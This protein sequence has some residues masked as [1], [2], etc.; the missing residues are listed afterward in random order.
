LWRTY[1]DAS[2]PQIFANRQISEIQNGF[3]EKCAL[4]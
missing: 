1:F 3:E 2:S 4:Q